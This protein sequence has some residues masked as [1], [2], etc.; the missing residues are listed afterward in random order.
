MTEMICV[1][2]E[3]RI[4]P[5]CGGLYK[6][7][8]AAA[9]ARIVDFVHANGDARIGAQLGHSG[10]KGSTKLMWEGEDEPLPD[11]NWPL[12]APSPLPY[13][14]GVNQEPREMTR[15]DMDEVREQYV[16]ATRA[17][18]QAGFDLLELHMAH[19]YL[20]SSFLSPLTNRREDEYGGEL[21]GRAPAIRSRSSRRAA[22]RGRRSGRCPCGSR[23]T[24]GTPAASTATRRSPSRRCCRRRAAT[25]STCPRGQVWPDQRP[26]YGRSFQTPFAD[27]IRNEVGIPTIAVGAIS[28]YDDVNTIV[29]SGRAD[30]CA[31]ARP[32]LYDP[33]WTLHAAA[34]QGY[35]GVAWVPQYRS[36]SRRPQDGKGDGIRRA[37]VRSFGE[38]E[39]GGERPPA[40]WR[41]RVTA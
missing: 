22:R 29:L 12:I 2:R 21:A 5:G 34:D 17:A 27:R 26:A 13:V 19:G 39:T 32:H 23:P 30:L 24:T 31:L 8:H 33:H 7:E 41:P 36:G 11:G 9:W 3:G 38:P 16:A 6:D 20:L 1:S 28:S 14:P 35:G 15:A 37:P 18:A 25:S 40:R 10:R 4:T